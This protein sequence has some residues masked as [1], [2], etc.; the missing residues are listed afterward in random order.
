MTELG[1]IDVNVQLGPVAGGA[2]GAPLATDES[3]PARSS[4]T[5]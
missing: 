1:F 5:P 4:I 2:R 3:G